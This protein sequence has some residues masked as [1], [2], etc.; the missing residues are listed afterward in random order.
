MTDQEEHEND[1]L[2]EKLEAA[3]EQL[4]EHFES[5]IIIATTSVGE[6]RKKS[7]VM[8]NAQSGSTFANQGA[9]RCWLIKR[10]AFDEAAGFEE[11][12]DTL[13]DEDD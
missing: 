13:E 8:F 4:G 9:V 3:A 2:Q 10:E 6:G 7:G 11:Y 12:E 5:L 1:A